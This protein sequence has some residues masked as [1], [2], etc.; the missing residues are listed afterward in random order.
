VP[1]RLT[2]SSAAAAGGISDNSAPRGGV[3]TKAPSPCQPKT[4]GS[5]PYAVK[6]RCRNV[7]VTVSSTVFST[8]RARRKSP[9]PARNSSTLSVMCQAMPPSSVVAAP[10]AP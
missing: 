8:G 9:A 6:P 5:A 10:G 4:G 1:A 2:A 7:S 3:R